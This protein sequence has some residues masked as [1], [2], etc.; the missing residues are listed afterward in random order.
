MYQLRCKKISEFLGFLN[1]L[2]PS[3]TV[4]LIIVWF[5]A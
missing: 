4:V 2:A 1:G 5:Q 3:M